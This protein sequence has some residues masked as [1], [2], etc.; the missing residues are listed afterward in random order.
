MSKSL[1]PKA[2]N[3]WRRCTSSRSKAPKCD[4][5]PFTCSNSAIW[6]LMYWNGNTS[7]PCFFPP[8][9]H[10]FTRNLTMNQRICHRPNSR[11]NICLPSPGERLALLYF[12]QQTLLLFIPNQNRNWPRI[13]ELSLVCSRRHKQLFWVALPLLRAFIRRRSA[14]C[15]P[16]PLH[17]GCRASWGCL[18]LL[19]LCPLLL[20]CQWVATEPVPSF[21]GWHHQT[22][23]YS[24]L[25]ARSV[26]YRW[27]PTWWA[28]L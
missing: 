25:R 26:S 8:Q 10:L 24:V 9:V 20:Q 12:G 14:R 15:E 4:E 27:T 13:C 5:P 2:K 23:A 21:P 17:A 28:W 3:T 7:F 1:A 11:A 6:A 19:Y 18:S 16:N 22:S